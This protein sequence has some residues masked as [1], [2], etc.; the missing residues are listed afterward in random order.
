VSEAGHKMGGSF[1]FVPVR[2]KATLVTDFEKIPFLFIIYLFTLPSYLY[3]HWLGN[4]NSYI[5]NYSGPKSYTKT[6]YK[7]SKPLGLYILYHK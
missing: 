5:A 1:M 6:I 3:I 4:H 2:I 7:L